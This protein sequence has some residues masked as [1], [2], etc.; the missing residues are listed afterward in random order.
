MPQVIDGEPAVQVSCHTGY[1]ILTH[2]KLSISRIHWDTE[3]LTIFFFV[4]FIACGEN[5]KWSGDRRTMS[6]IMHVRTCGIVKQDIIPICPRHRFTTCWSTWNSALCYI[7]SSFNFPSDCCAIWYTNKYPASANKEYRKW[8]Q[9]QVH[10]A[11]QWDMTT[12]VTYENLYTWL[13]WTWL[14]FKANG[15]FGNGPSWPL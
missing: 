5:W 13:D 1:C 6:N 3:E 2:C 10:C 11:C 4:V 14:Y 12:V 7:S 15:H 8:I 9:V